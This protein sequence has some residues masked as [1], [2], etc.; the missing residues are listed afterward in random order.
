MSVM[1]TVRDYYGLASVPAREGMDVLVLSTRFV[2]RYRVG[3]W[4]F[5][6]REAESLLKENA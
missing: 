6:G 2:Y 5:M 3:Q 4:L 1:K